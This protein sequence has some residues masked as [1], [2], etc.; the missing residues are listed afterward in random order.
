MLGFFLLPSWAATFLT[1]YSLPAWSYPKSYFGYYLSADGSQ[2]CN[3]SYIFPSF[4]PV[5]CWVSP[6]RGPKVLQIEEVPNNSPPS[7]LSQFLSSFPLP[8]V[9]RS[10]FCLL[11]LINYHVL[12]LLPLKYL[13]H[14]IFH[15]M[16]VTPALVQIPFF[17]YFITSPVCFS[18]L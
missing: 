17:L 2:I 12:L 11:P 9:G 4:R 13:T 1:I 15:Y 3:S 5:I 6:L 16:P 10:W 14:L 7:P 8:V 18:F